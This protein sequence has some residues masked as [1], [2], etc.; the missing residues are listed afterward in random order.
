MLE[1]NVSPLEEQDRIGTDLITPPLQYD[2][3][4]QTLK[5]RKRTY[6]I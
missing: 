4:N 6:L 3:H 5:V 1:I 2:P